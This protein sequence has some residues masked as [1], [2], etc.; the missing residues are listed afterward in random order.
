MSDIGVVL[1]YTTSAVFRAESLLRAA[2]MSPRLV[3][4]PRQL[5]SDCGLA[6]EFDWQARSAVEAILRRGA[7]E[8]ASLTLLPTPPSEMAGV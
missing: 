3:P 5:S 7:V 4:T 6:L 2:G 8:Y 1:F